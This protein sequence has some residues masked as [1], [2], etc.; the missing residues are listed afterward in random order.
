MFNEYALLPTSKL[1][2]NTSYYHAEKIPDIVQ[3]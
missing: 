3:L 1:N 2:N